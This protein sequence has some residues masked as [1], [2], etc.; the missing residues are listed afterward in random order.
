MPAGG[1][2]VDALDVDGGDFAAIAQLDDPVVVLVAGNGFGGLDGV[3]EFDFR[4]E[5]LFDQFENEGGGA[6]LERGGNFAHV[7]IAKDHVEAAVPADIGVGLVAGVDDG[8]AVHCVDGNQDAEKIRALGNLEKAG[9]AGS[10]LPF[11]AH[12]AG[13]GVNLPGDEKRDDAG[14]DAIPRDVA[15]HEVIVMAAVGVADEIGVVLVEAN[16]AAGIGQLFVA[17]PGALLDDALAGFVLRDQ[18]AQRAST[19]AS[20][21]RGGRGRCKSGRRSKGRGRS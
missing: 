5:V 7:G 11:H 10:L 1:L 16:F 19:R 13:A 14:D 3:G 20:S 21:T 2:E 15:A 4:D 17:A 12:L 9:L 8:A 18:L 6:D